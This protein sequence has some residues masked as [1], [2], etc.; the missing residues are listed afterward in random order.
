[1][2]DIIFSGSTFIDIHGQQ[3]LNLVDQQH[4]HTAYDLVGFDGAVQLVDYRRHT[5]RHIDNRPA[6]L[7]IRMT[8]TAV[9]QLILKE[10]KTI[11][12][13]HR[14]WVTTGDK[15]T[16]PDSDHL[17]MQIAPLGQDQYAYLALCRNVTH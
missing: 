4:D 5:P 14:L 11:R 3:L 10:T 17:F 6:R 12:P 2:N 15:N 8:E 16:T 9:L 13:R 7:T 1:M